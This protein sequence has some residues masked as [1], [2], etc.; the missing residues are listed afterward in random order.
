MI[1]DI[2]SKAFTR[3]LVFL[4]VTKQLLVLRDLDVPIVIA[5]IIDDYTGY[6][7]SENTQY[8]WNILG[9]RLKEGYDNWLRNR[10]CFVRTTEYACKNSIW[11]WM[12]Q[13]H[14]IFDNRGDFIV[15]SRRPKFMRGYIL[16]FI[17]FNEFLRTLQS[18]QDPN[19]WDTS[20]SVDDG[21]N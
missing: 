19:N 16:D 8:V 9:Q 14:R 6:G 2:N 7:I 5:N 12:G 3:F 15:S 10:V 1:Y 13:D 21:W 11:T 17:Q 20:S 18:Y 4:A